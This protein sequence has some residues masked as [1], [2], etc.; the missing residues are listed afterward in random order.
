MSCRILLIEDQELVR[1]S[2]ASL[3]NSTKLFRVT[4]TLECATSALALLQQNDAFD[5][6]LCDYHLKTDTAETLLR[7]RRNLPDIPIVL[8]TSHFNAMVLQHCLSLGAKGFLFKE[9]SIEEFVSALTTVANGGEYFSAPEAGTATPVTHHEQV[10]LQLTETELDILRW[11]AT[12]M[13]NKQIAISTG[14]SAET[15]KSHIARILKKLNCSTRT[16][17]VTKANHFKLLQ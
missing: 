15:V 17:A 7:E 2:L 16:Q 9:S 4:H 13:S 8:L 1:E 6:I 3:L 14:K 10:N 12:G 11:L 5:L